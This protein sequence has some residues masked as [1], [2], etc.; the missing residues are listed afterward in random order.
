MGGEPPAAGLSL[1][2]FYLLADGFVILI[3]ALVLWS[4]LRLP[5]WY[6]RFG[7]LPNSRRVIVPLMRELL[8]PVALFLGIPVVV[9]SWSDLVFSYPD[10]GWW[11]LVTLACLLL[12]GISRGMLAFLVLRR[13][14]APTRLASASPPLT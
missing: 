3:S 7:Q 11:L 8:L 4:L 6:K 14:A 12:T 9:G 10:L 5:R 13:K 1:G 2:T